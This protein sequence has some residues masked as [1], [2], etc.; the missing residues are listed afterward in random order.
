MRQFVMKV[1]KILKLF[2]PVPLGHANKIAQQMFVIIHS[3]HFANFFCNLE[4]LNAGSV[5]KGS[6]AVQRRLVRS[7]F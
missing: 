4:N 6:E 2:C 7:F 3:E 5:D 1:P